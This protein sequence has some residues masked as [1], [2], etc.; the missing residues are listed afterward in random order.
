MM[1]RTAE[2]AFVHFSY[3]QQEDSTFT[4]IPG[5][6]REK[7][8]DSDLA[9]R[10]L[11]K[12]L[13]GCICRHPLCGPPPLDSP[14]PTR[15][16]DVWGVDNS[17]VALVETAGQRGRYIALSHC[18]GKSP[19]LIT[20]KSTLEV[21][22][23]GIS[24][25]A[26]P[27]TFGDAVT[28]TKKLGVKYLWID[29]LC[30]IQDDPS[31]WER[32]ASTMGH[33][34]RDSY[35][36]IS[37]ASCTDSH[38]GCFPSRRTR[39][40]YVSVATRSLGYDVPRS[41][42]YSLNGY[43][44]GPPGPGQLSF[45]R[46]FEE[47]LP[48]SA[49]T[50]LMPQ[51]TNIGAFGKRLDPLADEHLS[52]RAWTLQERLLSP[53][54]IHYARDQIYFECESGIRSEDGFL[55]T[56]TYFSM[57]RLV[58][59]QLIPREEHGL[60]PNE[61]ISFLATPSVFRRSCTRLMGGWLSLVEDYSKRS[62]TM[63]QDKL[64]AVAGVARVLADITGDT[65]YAGVW[66]T[67]LYED[68]FWRVYAEEE[69]IEM[70]GVAHRP[71][72]GRILGSISRPNTWRAPSWSWASLDAPIRFLP[73]AYKNL[74]AKVINCHTEPAGQDKFGAV[75]AGALEILVCVTS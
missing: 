72:K 12:W 52:T 58:E 66:R 55:L 51:Y 31:D 37:A 69:E 75:L 14:L 11:E 49:A 9:F 39:D 57:R 71:R 30:I 53:R 73:L 61:G 21:Y 35:V 47:W 13:D 60:R 44:T 16:I 23:D 1:V 6:L 4:T 18:W 22:K 64:T 10:R 7:W 36:T 65:Y 8:S 25:S 45:L 74:V 24:I 15:V 5:R 41:S 46:A 27:K 3:S 43:L 17:F 20:T 63:P 42:S 2:L 32:E 68:L 59:T 33:V 50:H 34:Y 62:L 29:S 28:I 56:E 40:S 19:R 54:I 26:L 38:D 70:H 67:H 48:G